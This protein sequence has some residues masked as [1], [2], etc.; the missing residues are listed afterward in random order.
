[1]APSLPQRV[2]E[3]DPRSRLVDS[4]DVPSSGVDDE[5]DVTAG[6]IGID[7][8]PPGGASMLSCIINQVSARFFPALPE[9]AI[10]QLVF[11]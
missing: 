9:G 4:G 1:M 11:F 5:S 10:C 7:E 2:E 8:A 3:E 6:A